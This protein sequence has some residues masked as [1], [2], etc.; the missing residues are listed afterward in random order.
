MRDLQNLDRP[1]L[2]AVG[3]RIHAHRHAVARFALLAVPVAGLRNLAA[4]VALVN[5]AHHTTSIRAP[6]RIHTRPASLRFDNLAICHL[7]ICNSTHPVNIGDVIKRSG[8]HLVGQMLNKPAAAQ[9]I[10]HSGDPGFMSQ[11]LLCA[12]GNRHGLLCRQAERLIHAV[13][14][15]ALAP[16]QHRGHRLISHAHD[17]VH[18]LLLGK[19]AAGRLHVGFHE[20]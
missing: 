7:T 3:V 16:A 12:Q 10:S 6:R 5:P 9:R 1:A 19:R 2:I 4:E 14:V 17:I 8:F 20:P 11:N 18:R 13:G 15:Q